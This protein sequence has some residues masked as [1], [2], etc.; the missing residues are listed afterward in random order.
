MTVPYEKQLPM[1]LRV[2]WLISSI[3]ACLIYGDDETVSSLCKFM[4]QFWSSIPKEKR[5]QLFRESSTGLKFLLD[6]KVDEN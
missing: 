2:H 5:I 6:L 3:E 1:T 4:M